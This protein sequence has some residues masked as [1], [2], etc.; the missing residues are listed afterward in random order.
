MAQRPLSPH[1]F[2]YRFAYTMATSIFHRATGVALSGGLLLLVA[3]LLALASGPDAYAGFAA[4]AG[5]W[6]VRALLALL[7]LSFCYHFANGIRHLTWDAGF[8]MERAQA[9]LSAKLV[10]A[11][12]VISAPLLIYLLLFRGA[13]P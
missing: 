12:V 6:P 1:V 9:R 5:S 8:G 4:C 13:T 2:I 3:W 10:V 11:F 7:V